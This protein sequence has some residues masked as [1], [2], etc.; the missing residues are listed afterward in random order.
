MSRTLVIKSIEQGFENPLS[1]KGRLFARIMNRRNYTIEYVD[2][3]EDE[4]A[5][6]RN[7]AGRRLY[8]YDDETFSSFWD[9]VSSNTAEALLEAFDGLS[10][11]TVG[12]ARFL[13]FPD[14]KLTPAPTA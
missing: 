13:R 3:D 8:D 11:S 10:A 1:D 2:D 7:G 12:K 9:E 14:T 4:I 6:I 5:Y